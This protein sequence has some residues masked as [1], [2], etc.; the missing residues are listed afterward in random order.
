MICDAS[1][2]LQAYHCPVEASLSSVC[3]HELPICVKS[4]GLSLPASLPLLRL[5][6]CCLICRERGFICTRVRMAVCHGGQG[7]TLEAFARAAGLPLPA[8]HCVR[9]VAER[10]DEGH[11]PRCHQHRRDGTCMNSLE[12]RTKLIEP[13]TLA[14]PSLSL[15]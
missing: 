2:K 4:Q 1:A 3:S 8:F 15:S 5:H 14:N 7:V 6:V 9:E 10:G 12:V 13:Y 11:S